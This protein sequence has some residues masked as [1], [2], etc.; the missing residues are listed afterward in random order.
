[1]R[2]LIPSVCSSAPLPQPERADLSTPQAADSCT[3]ALNNGG[4][5]IALIDTAST[6]RDRFEYSATSEGVQVLTGH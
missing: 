2:D 4:D 5:E 1:M 6:E 3:N